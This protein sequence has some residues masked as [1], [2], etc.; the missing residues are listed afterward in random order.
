MEGSVL[1]KQYVSEEKE[2]DIKK[3]KQI[4]L[5]QERY[6]DYNL[7]IIVVFLVSFGLVMLY[8]ASAYSAQREF[9]NDLHFFMN[10]GLISV[11]GIVGMLVISRI[12]Y[13]LY[14]H[15]ALLIFILSIV[16]LFLVLTPLGVEINGAR[17]WLMLPIVE[18][19]IQPSEVT[20]IAVIIFLSHRLCKLGKKA[21]T[22]WGGLQI[23]GI[24]GLAGF[25]VLELTDHLSTA[26][27]VMAIAVGL[28]FVMHPRY[29]LFVF[30]TALGAI[31][32]WIGLRII[33]ARITTSTDFRMWRIISWLDPE[34][35]V[36][37]GGFQVLQGLYAIG[38]GGF[39]GRG[40]GNSTQKLGVIPEAHNDMII[41]VISEELGVFG[42][43]IIL[44]LFAMLL[45]RLMFIAQNA[46]DLFGS[47]LVIGIF[48]QIAVQVVLNI[49]VVTNMIPTT[50]I[51]LPFI[52]FGGTSVMFLLAQIGIALGVSR[53]I[54]LK[55]E[56][57]ES[58]E[59]GRLQRTKGQS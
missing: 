45:Y 39:F 4:S 41:A 8:S 11:L 21:Y 15:F 13:R 17:R 25:L 18:R 43:I 30:F 44:L 28:Y 40:L 6:F 38:S 51:T 50:G 54:K 34:G 14:K 29:K 47:L 5:K 26:I 3:K 27:V 37:T 1:P 32:T 31:A 59:G 22:F 56:N 36:E 48:I 35:H 2:Q 46:P 57:Y 10:Q 49:A 53:Q 42:V 16:M 58:E 19:T 7:F 23:L 12:N 9:G 20:K 52:S 55:G 33:S 24:G